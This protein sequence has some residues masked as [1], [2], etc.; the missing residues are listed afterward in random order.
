MAVALENLYLLRLA[1]FVNVNEVPVVD[2]DGKEEISTKEDEDGVRLTVRG[3]G[4]DVWRDDDEAA[5][6]EPTEES[7][8]LTVDS[9][10]ALIGVVPSDDL[11]T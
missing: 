4:S 5:H 2:K 8:K 6:S 7:R 10:C 3:G 11:E 9:P 1:C